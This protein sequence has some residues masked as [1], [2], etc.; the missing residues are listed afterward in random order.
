MAKCK[1][2][3]QR[4][5]RE[6]HQ[7]PS[8]GE[9]VRQQENQRYGTDCRGG[10]LPKQ[11]GRLERIWQA[12]WALEAEAKAAGE[13]DKISSRGDEH[14]SSR[15]RK[16]TLNISAEFGRRPGRRRRGNA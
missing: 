11:L 5:Q 3:E 15:K 9:P 12:K 2:K 8:E 10:K 4:L 14:N 16:V 6:V 7:L 1:E 13:Q